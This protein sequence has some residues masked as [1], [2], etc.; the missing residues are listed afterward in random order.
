M[1]TTNHLYGVYMNY[2]SHPLE[3]ENAILPP[4]PEDLP[5]DLFGENNEGNDCCTFV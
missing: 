5:P 2:Q 4:I 1:V 3:D